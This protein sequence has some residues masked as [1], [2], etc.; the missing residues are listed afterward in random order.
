MIEDVQRDAEDRMK[1]AIEAL[2]RDLQ[3]I[4]TGRATPALLDRVTVE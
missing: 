3:T 1:K 2:R 4:R